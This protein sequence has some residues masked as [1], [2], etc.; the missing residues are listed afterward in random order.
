MKSSFSSTLPFIIITLKILVIFTNSFL[1]QKSKPEKEIY[2]RFLRN[3]LDVFLQ[4]T[5]RCPISTELIVPSVYKY[6]SLYKFILTL[7]PLF[8]DGKFLAPWNP[9]TFFSILFFFQSVSLS[10]IRINQLTLV[11]TVWGLNVIWSL[12]S[13][14]FCCKCLKCAWLVHKYLSYFNSHFLFSICLRIIWNCFYLFIP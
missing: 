11:I 13:I 10:P 1:S 14:L 2:F 4:Y 3:I 12:F 5:T 9:L 8:R 6:F 7:S